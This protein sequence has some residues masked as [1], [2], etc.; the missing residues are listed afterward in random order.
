MLQEFFQNPFW[1]REIA[2]N[3]VREYA[4]SL[5]V[6]FILI[7]TF[8]LFYLLILRKLTKF[9][10]N[11][12]TTLDDVLISILKS[13]KPP[14][15]IFF[16]VYLAFRTLNTGIRIDKVLYAVLIIWVVYQVI[17]ALEIFVD[18]VLS[19]RMGDDGK[20]KGASDLMRIIIR[21]TLWSIGGLMVLSNLGVNIT[22]LIAGLGIGGV[23]VALALQNI[24]GD[25]FSSFAIYL[26]KPFV[27]GD[28]IVVGDKMGVVKKIGIKTTRIQALQGEELVLS[29]KDLTSSIIQNFKQMQLRRVPFVV[30]VLYETPIEKLRKIPE[31]IKKIIEDVEKT[32]FDRAHFQSFRDSSLGFEIV[33]FVE[34]AD[35]NLYMDVQQDINFKIL[36]YFEK[37]NIEIAY[38]TQTLYLNEVRNKKP[39]SK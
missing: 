3:T 37:E 9:A 25:L 19:K 26:D 21:I 11:T 13:L 36:E 31:N 8:R 24:L 17:L 39:K 28:F 15:Y 14:F 29:N 12:K 1:Y 22:S 34:S 23:A 20:A 10:E 18:Y 6:F 38:P 7:F 30:G 32:K 27:V 2:G 33:Y 16:A 35:Y 5:I 4:I